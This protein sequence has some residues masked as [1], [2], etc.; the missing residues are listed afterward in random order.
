MGE[1]QRRTLASL[2]YE[3]SEWDRRRAECVDISD[4]DPIL[5]RGLVAYAARQAAMYRGLRDK[6]SKL[7]RGEQFIDE[8]RE[9]AQGEDVVLRGAILDDGS[10]NEQADD[11]DVDLLG[12]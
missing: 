3:A 8:G 12:D 9:V 1:E 11:N 6:F 7:W 5:A 2:E 4:G 10:D